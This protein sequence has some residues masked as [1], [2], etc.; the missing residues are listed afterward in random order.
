[1]P[2]SLYSIVGT[3]IRLETPHKE[4]NE[5][6]DYM[7]Q[8]FLCAAPAGSA[9]TIKVLPTDKS[10]CYAIYR[11]GKIAI[12]W[13]RELNEVP[14]AILTKALENIV[15]GYAINQIDKKELITIHSGAISKNGDGILIL[16]DSGNG[17]STLTIELVANHDWLYLTDEVGLLDKNNI[18]YPFF[19]TVSCCK[20]IVSCKSNAIVMI[21]KRWAMHQCGEDYHVAVPKEKYGIST[22]LKAIFFVK[23]SPDK[24]PCIEPVKKSE[25]LLRLMNAQ[26]GRAKS[27]ATLEQMAEVVKKA[28]AFQLV[29]NNAAAAARL[30]TKRIETA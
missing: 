29:H 10:G 6:C 22:S 9:A 30:L 7:W 17:K 21:D 13:G 12:D 23:Y 15:S 25:A 20:D 14:Y 28:D 11:Q 1:M 18:I 16:G 27:V 8:E 5:F 19:K 24:E 2:E 26:I 4:I 3:L